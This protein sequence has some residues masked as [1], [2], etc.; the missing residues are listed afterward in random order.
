MPEVISE[1]QGVSMSPF[2]KPGDRLRIEIYSQP[3][4][5][6][7]NPGE[8]LLQKQED[9]W[10]VHRLCCFN[11]QFSLRADRGSWMSR[12]PVWGKVIGFE[13]GGSWDSKVPLFGSVLARQ[14][15]WP[16]PKRIKVLFSYLLGWGARIY[17]RRWV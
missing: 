9:Q 5:L 15:H 13:E 3:R 7:G 16:I 11:N 8:I 1:H 12:D 4:E 17:Y 10:L 2:L 6:N 14:T